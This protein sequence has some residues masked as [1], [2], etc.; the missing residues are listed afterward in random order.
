MGSKLP[1][2]QFPVSVVQYAIDMDNGALYM[3]ADGQ[4][5]KAGNIT[6]CVPTSG[7]AKTGALITGLNGKTVYAAA[8]LVSATANGGFGAQSA[9]ANFGA[10]PFA[11]PVPAGYNSGL[12]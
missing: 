3:G 1:S 6:T 8:T 11:Y 2:L 5:G 12:Y 7:A 10:T 9:T 4:W